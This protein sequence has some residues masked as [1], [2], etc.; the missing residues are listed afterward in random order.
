MML[1]SKLLCEIQALPGHVTP[2]ALVP[3]SCH[4]DMT[5]FAVMCSI[6]FRKQYLHEF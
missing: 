1:V 4:I 5:E 2:P 3:V 6:R